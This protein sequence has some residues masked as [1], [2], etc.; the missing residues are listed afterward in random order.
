[1]EGSLNQFRTFIGKDKLSPYDITENLSTRF[2]SF[3]L[4]K[5]TGKSPSDYFGA[6]KPVIKSA[7][8]EGSFRFNPAEDTRSKVNPS[9]R[10]REFLEADQYVSLLKT[11]IIN[12]EL[13]DAFIVSGLRQC[14]VS[15][16]NWTISKTLILLPGLYSGRPASHLNLHCTQRLNLSWNIKPVNTRADYRK[17]I[18]SPERASLLSS[19]ARRCKNRLASM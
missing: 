19:Y 18:G 14:D 8:K 17:R 10:I 15:N 11:G 16:M 7:T 2:R 13:R 6:Y 3:L 12:K 5:L 1:M 9:K 4:D